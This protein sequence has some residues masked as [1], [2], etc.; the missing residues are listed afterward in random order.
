ML[1]A[2]IILLLI[3][4]FVLCFD[5]LD[6]VLNWLGRIKIGT[7]TDD[8]EWTSATRK[9]IDKWLN[10]GTPKLPLNDNKRLK[11]FS[12]IKN[13]G[14]TESTAYWQDAAVLKAASAMGDRDEGVFRL[15]DRY[16]ETESGKW[17]TEPERID[18]AMLAYEMLCCDY[19][20]ND[21]IKPAM[22]YTASH[23][24]KL[25]EKYGTIPYN[26]ISKDV[27]FVDTVGMVCPFLMKYAVVYNESRF[28]DIALEQIEEYRKNGFEKETKI[29]GHCFNAETQAPL[30]IYGWAR[31]CAWWAVGITDSL[32]SLMESKS[33]F[34][35]KAK[36][37]K[38]CVE[39]AGVMKKY[40]RDDGAFERMIFTSSLED[41]SAGAMLAYCFAYLAKL[42]DNDD[43][44]ELSK[45]TIR[46]LKSC[47][48]RG[49]VIDYAQGDT[50]GIGF[51]ADGFR[52]VPAAQGFAVAAAEEI[53]F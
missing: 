5:F 35:E 19:I 47:T 22:D 36:L 30:G 7:I 37:L 1:T 34:I 4:I 51:Y 20:D 33:Y 40:Q 6:A 50:M 46:H 13:I 53:G 11:L 39:F 23:L 52:V 31:G 21:M 49:G 18:S 27:R 12:A 42:T 24:E 15:L 28:V 14:K 41:S 10:K 38:Y 43:L 17:K 44:E 45:K 16:I 48:R 26:E 9:V 8:G 25:Y 3:V 32:K 2:I 29:P